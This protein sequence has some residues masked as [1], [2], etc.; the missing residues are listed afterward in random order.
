MR[1]I[2]FSAQIL[3]FSSIAYCEQSPSSQMQERPCAFC[4]SR[5]LERQTFYEDDF[6]LALYTHKPIYPGHCLVIP[7]RHVERFEELS[8][9]EI[10]QIGATIQKVDEAVK[11]VFGTSAYLIL[12]KNG[13]EVGQTVPHVHFHYIPRE[14]GDDSTIMFLVR[15]FGINLLGPISAQEMEKNVSLLC[16]AMQD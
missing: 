4:D 6:V 2:L 7:K 1:A 15:M 11:K 12:Q 3:L 9:A 16:Q 14:A 8:P 5:V 10:T 13:E